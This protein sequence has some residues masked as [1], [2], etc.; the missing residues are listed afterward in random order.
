M[1]SEPALSRMTETDY[2]VLYRNEYGEIVVG[3]EKVS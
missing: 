2:D 3:G 1:G